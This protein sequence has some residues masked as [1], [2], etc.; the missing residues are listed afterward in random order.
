MN[1]FIGFLGKKKVVVNDNQ[2]GVA[3]QRLPKDTL[4]R[5][6]F[7]VFI[8]C[9]T[10]FTGRCSKYMSSINNEVAVFENVYLKDVL[11][12]ISEQLEVD[13]ELVLLTWAGDKIRQRRYLWVRS[14]TGK[15]YFIKIG[16]GQD[17]KVKFMKDVQMGS[18]YFSNNTNPSEVEFVKGALYEFDKNIT[19]TISPCLFELN[20]SP[21]YKD[22]IKLKPLFD[23][24]RKTSLCMQPFVLS[25]FSWLEL[26]NYSTK[27]C[28][29]LHMHVQAGSKIST[30]LNHGDLG[31]ENVLYGD[32]AYVIDFECSGKKLPFLVDPIAVFLD[33]RSAKNPELVW[34]QFSEFNELEVALA[35]CFLA[36]NNFPP[37]IKALGERLI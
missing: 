37:A 2:I 12:F 13:V 19:L 14:V 26:N 29:F 27:F 17:N 24:L 8:Y 36:S 34:D 23:D 25:A 9:Y 15:Y 6:C 32:V 21:E 31:S 30:C 20:C 35:I 5:Y 22:W 33:S 3:F 28:D 11:H 16:K 7:A 18:F 1:I 4:I 10:F